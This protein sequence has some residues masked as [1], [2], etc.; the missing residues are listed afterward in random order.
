MNKNIESEARRFSNL[1]GYSSEHRDHDMVKMKYLLVFSLRCCIRAVSYRL[2]NSLKCRNI[3]FII[4][5]IY[6]ESAHSAHAL[7]RLSLI[8]I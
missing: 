4:Y 7:K 3:D 1:V 6:D 5:I 2:T 8:H